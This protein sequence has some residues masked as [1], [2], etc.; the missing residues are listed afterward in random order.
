MTSDKKYADCNVAGNGELIS[1]NSN[2][3][4]I[5]LSVG[6]INIDFILLYSNTILFIG[7]Q[8]LHLLIQS[9][10]IL[11]QYV[12]FLPFIVRKANKFNFITILQTY[13]YFTVNIHMCVNQR[14]PL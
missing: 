10:C 8:T 2:K 5:K 4:E 3:V 9:T 14:I 11:H 6:V 13:F 7:Q 1:E 12:N